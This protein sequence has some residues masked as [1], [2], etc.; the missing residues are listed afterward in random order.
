MN[1]TTSNNLIVKS[2]FPHSIDNILIKGNYKN[3]RF[4]VDKRVDQIVHRDRFNVTKFKF[5]E[6]KLLYSIRS[7]FQI[8]VTHYELL[9]SMQV[10]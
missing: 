1:V 7:K 10:R 4:S 5:E 6:I 8:G 2:T 9:P 3:E